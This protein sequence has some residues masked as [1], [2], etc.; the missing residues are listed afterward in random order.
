MHH[1]LLS[2][3]EHGRRPDYETRNAFERELL[4]KL[5]PD[6]PESLVMV[7]MLDLRDHGGHYG[8]QKHEILIRSRVRGQS[9]REIARALGIAQTTV[10]RR[11]S[12]AID[13]I[14]AY[15]RG[16]RVAKS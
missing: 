12:E 5:A 7:A 16:F 13:Y 15:C 3:I 11:E 6:Y 4:L 9:Q 2:Y 1:K 14:N 8:H 10:S